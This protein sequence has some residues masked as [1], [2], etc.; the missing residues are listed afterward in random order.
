MRYV[1]GIYS[2]NCNQR[3]HGLRCRKRPVIWGADTLFGLLEN[4]RVANGLDE[5]DY[6]GESS[7]HGDF[8]TVID[9]VEGLMEYAAMLRRRAHPGAA[10]QYTRAVARGIREAVEVGDLLAVEGTSGEPHGQTDGTTL[11]AGRPSVGG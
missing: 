1:I 11:G 2:E 3:V 9:T 8:S 6:A 5:I 7:D 4:S 10:G